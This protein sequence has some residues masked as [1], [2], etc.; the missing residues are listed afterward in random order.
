MFRAGIKKTR[1]GL[2]F[3]M[4]S[5]YVAVI[6]NVPLL[7]K[8]NPIRVINCRKLAW[9]LSFYRVTQL[10]WLCLQHTDCITTVVPT[11]SVTSHKA[12]YDKDDH[13]KLSQDLKKKNYVTIY[14]KQRFNRFT[15]S[16]RPVP[17]LPPV[18]KND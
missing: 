16:D 9:W 18:A 17:Y 7:D 2:R 4:L 10:Q 14:F 12:N 1:S 13:N 11:W 3:N 8:E 5:L 15:F 6:W